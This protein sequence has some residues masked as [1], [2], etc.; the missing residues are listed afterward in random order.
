MIA[1]NRWKISWFVLICLLHLFFITF[2][3]A[4]SLCVFFSSI[5][6]FFSTALLHKIW[7]SFRDFWANS[8]ICEGNRREKRGYPSLPDAFS[9]FKDRTWRVCLLRELLHQ[10]KAPMPQGKDGCPVFERERRSR[11]A[12]AQFPDVVVEFPLLTCSYLCSPGWG[13]GKGWRSPA[14]LFL[15]SGDKLNF[16]VI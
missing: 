3:R 6:P 8:S 4:E 7:F 11:G 16:T 15:C 12:M 9:W 5:P 1:W 2:F 13:E 10:Q 14:Q